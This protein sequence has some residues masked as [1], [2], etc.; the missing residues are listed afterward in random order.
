MTCRYC[1]T[2]LPEGAMFCGECGRSVAVTRQTLTTRSPKPVAEVFVP[3]VDEPEP[4]AE[5]VAEPV[6]ASSVEASSGDVVEDPS[7]EYVDDPEPEHDLSLEVVAGPE[8]VVEPEPEPEPEPVVEPES[9]PESER[10]PVAEPD[11]APALDAPP[12]PP[13]VAAAPIVEPVASIPSVVDEEHVDVEAT[14]IT[15]VGQGGDRFVLQFSTGESVTVFG[16]GIIG[17]N[18]NPEPGE[19]FDQRVTIVDPGK[20]VSKTHLEFGQTSGAFWVNDR[21]SGNGSGIRQPEGERVH[22]DPG[23][24]YLVARGSRVDIG[25]QFFI[26]S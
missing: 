25:E 4:V 11:P 8:P 22:C 12:E 16:T 9:E 17:R 21:F 20:S 26:V 6:E 14:R 5:P 24:R 3:A 10:E 15:P 18:P 13:L 7:D 23:K 2:E 1:G 19:Y